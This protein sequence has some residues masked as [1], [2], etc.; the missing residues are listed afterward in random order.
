[1]KVTISM[2]IY[3]LCSLTSLHAQQTQVSKLAILSDVHVMAPEL[4]PQPGKAFDKY[5]NADR[6]MLAESVELLDSAV[7]EV[8]RSG[9]QVVLMPGDLTK[10]GEYVSHRL[11]REHCLKTLEKQGIRVFVIPGNHDI[12]N[13]HASVYQGDTAIRT[14]S[15]SPAEFAEIYH[16]FGYGEAIARDDHSLSYVV[17]L[18][19]HTRLLALD[20]CRYE[21]NDFGKNT[22]VT[23]GRLKKTTME[24][25]R[26]QME[27]AKRHNCKVLTMM[28]H[29]LVAHWS[30]QPKIMGDYLIDD[31]KRN[32][33]KLARLGIRFVFTG[34]FHAQDIAT[35]K[36]GKHLISDIETGSTVSYPH[37]F[38]IVELDGGT[39][40]VST[41]KIRQLGTVTGGVTALEQRSA[42][43]AKSAIE[44]L[45]DQMMVKK[46][47]LEPRQEAAQVLGQAYLMHLA[48]DERPSAAYW[49][50]LRAATKKLRRYSWKYSLL[51]HYVAKSLIHDH[52]ADNETTLS[53]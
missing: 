41:R 35:L 53:W 8:L 22:C 5:I 39:F 50:R 19:P 36:A 4:L 2:F 46:V 17:Q 48:G 3:C 20:A 14:R 15:V 43:Y 26:Q 18:D 34:H 45:T 52:S 33:R 16:N 24:F 23:G 49:T 31:W 29:G 47:P 38:R 12:N 30:L 21:D 40:K 44:T 6:K 28:H 10:D 11:L 32:A 37:A 13:P 27:D 1:M 25:I 7:A 9:A 42:N 51:L